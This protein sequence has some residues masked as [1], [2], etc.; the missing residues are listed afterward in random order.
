MGQRYQ[1]AAGTPSWVDVSSDD[2]DASAAFYAG[3]LGWEVAEAGP[4]QQ[5][6]GYRMLQLG[7][8]DVAGLGP[9][10]PGVA[11]AW[12]SY[13]AVDDA[14]ATAKAVEAAG[15]MVVLPPTDLG[16][17]GRLA[18]LV[19]D[20]GAGFSIWQAGRHQGAD[21]VNEPGSLA[22]TE[23]ARRDPDR[24][25]AFYRAV[26]GW[27]AEV[28]DMPGAPTSSYTTFS[29]PEAG[30]APLAGMVQMNED[31]P[32]DIA[33]HWMVY[34]AV[35][36]CDAAVARVGELGGVVSIP[37]FDMPNGRIAVVADDRGA[38][39]SLIALAAP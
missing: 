21:L 7:G 9:A 20:G 16:D 5:A 30:G 29:L 13:I 35:A 1:Y 37:P 4:V 38:T 25:R 6:A 14:D 19:D 17:A 15:G 32:D 2:M 23:L 18:I 10:V 28:G 34:L 24:A 36:D 27:D 26:F 31:W 12:T 8:L 33:P 22:W 3:L 39:F 11:P